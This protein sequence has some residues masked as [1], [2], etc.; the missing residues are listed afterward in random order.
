MFS[1]RHLS[2]LVQH[3]THTVISSCREKILRLSFITFTLIIF[4]VLTSCAFNSQQNKSDAVLFL[5]WDGADTPQL[6]RQ[7]LGGE[8]HQ[9]TAFGAGVYDY[10]LSPDGR[11]TILSVTTETDHELWLMDMDDTSMEQ[12]YPCPA[13][14]CSNFTWHADSRRLLFEQRKLND[15]KLAGAPVLYWLDTKTGDVQRLM[16]DEN[17]YSANG[18]IS[19][20]G[21]WVSYHSP[22]QEGT[23]LY[24][25]EDGGSQ[26]IL[27]EGGRPAAWN[28]SGTAVVLPQVD[29]VIV[30]SEEGDD[31]ETHEHD[32]QLAVH[33]LRIDLETGEQR[34]LSGDLRVD[35][36]VPA[37]SPD[38][39]WIAFGR[40]PP[41][42]GSA[43]QLWL[44]RADGSESRALS[45][46]PNINH[47]PPSWSA[48]GRFLLY[49][50][51]SQDD[52][53]AV[54]EIWLLDVESGEKE[55]ITSSGMQP[56]WIYGP[57]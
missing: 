53:D 46:D 41:L 6:F 11:Y 55:R 26:F 25:L 47:G 39:Q 12:I 4:F 2:Y 57:T 43:R 20:E 27:N 30:H 50:Q 42:T 19:P 8:P 16:E 54:P 18:R 17:S 5:D 24:H 52:L 44:I 35:D 7:E 14:A 1:W 29:L 34:N 22:L 37:W 9:L 3:R 31:H 51:T 38:G 48:D 40:R 21:E 13:A 15:D 28:P 33:L 32:Y 23:V 36:S 10:A 56:T 45:D 49:Q